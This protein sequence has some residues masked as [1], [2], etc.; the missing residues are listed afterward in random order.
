MLKQHMGADPAHASACNAVT[1]V[2]RRH[3][4]NAVVVRWSSRAVQSLAANDDNSR[5]LAAVDACR[6]VTHA[7]KD[8]AADA[9]AV[10]AACRAVA[11]LARLQTN[12]IKLG[13]AGARAA[14]ATAVQLHSR[15]TVLVTQAL[16]A[17]NSLPVSSGAAEAAVCKAVVAAMNKHA[18]KAAVVLQGC[19]AVARIAQSSAAH[20]QLLLSTTG[21]NAVVAA[22]LKQHARDADGKRQCALAAARLTNDSTD[23]S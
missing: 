8:H 19:T 21:A 17:M 7:L 3:A 12:S 23:N 10:E 2:M 5:T 13:S 14:A 22:A 18:S 20:R 15:T 11:A 16:L 6:L 4:G 9:A 1:A